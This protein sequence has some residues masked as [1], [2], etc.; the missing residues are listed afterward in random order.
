MAM[1][2]PSGAIWGSVRRTIRPMLSMPKRAEKRVAERAINRSAS[3]LRSIANL[4]GNYDYG[5]AGQ[6][7]A[8]STTLA[9]NSAL[10]RKRSFPTSRAPA[11]SAAW[12]A[13]KP[14]VVLAMALF[15][16]LVLVAVALG[17]VGVV[18]KGLFYL[19]IIGIVILAAD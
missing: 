5:I 7:K 15:L 12:A 19:L 10:F 14:G 1:D 4:R 3:F 17:I 18:A 11:A 13:A 9:K 6:G 2:L 16:L 8:Q